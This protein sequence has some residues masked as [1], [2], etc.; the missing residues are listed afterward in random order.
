MSAR[1]LSAAHWSASNREFACTR[2]S[3][4]GASFFAQICERFWKPKRNK[5]ARSFEF[6][7]PRTSGRRRCCHG[8]G[9]V[10]KPKRGGLVRGPRADACRVGHARGQRRRRQQRGGDSGDGGGGAGVGVHVRASR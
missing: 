6:G 2:G 1:Q 7:S 5:S 10:T 8:G 4:R 9:P 3:S